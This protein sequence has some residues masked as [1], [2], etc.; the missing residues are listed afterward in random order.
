M[1]CSRP[2]G[3]VEIVK[4]LVKAY[5]KDAKLTTDK[6]SKKIDICVKK[7]R[8]WEIFIEALEIYPHSIKN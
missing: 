8:V 3:A 2:S 7:C 6:V 1:A 4:T 5:G